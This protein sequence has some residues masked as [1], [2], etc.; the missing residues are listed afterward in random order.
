MRMR[1]IE[2]VIELYNRR[3]T[4][5][6]KILTITT[7]NTIKPKVSDIKVASP[8]AHDATPKKFSKKIPKRNEIVNYLII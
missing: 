5:N 6:K 7:E 1:L 2:I 4:C 3:M 8:Y